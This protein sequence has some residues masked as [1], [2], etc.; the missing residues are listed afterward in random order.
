MELPNTTTHLDESTFLNQLLVSEQG[1]LKELAQIRESRESVIRAAIYLRVSTARQA[2]KDK[3]SLKEQQLQANEVI[4]NNGWI[5]S[6]VYK[7]AGK[8][9]KQV[10]GRDEYIRMIDD[11][12]NRKFEVIVFWDFD[13]F[14]RGGAGQVLSVRDELMGYGVQITSVTCPIEIDDPRYMTSETSFPKDVLIAM[15]AI[16]AKEENRK[17]A[18]R[19]S[20]AKNDKAKRGYIPCKVPYGYRKIVKHNDDGTKTEK[21]VIHKKEALVVQE[22]FNLYDQSSVGILRVAEHLNLKGIPASR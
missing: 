10:V 16:V 15:Q 5:L 7:D 12:K 17:R 11:A 21:V 3:A 14:G 2:T 13:R 1:K 4:K 8:S 19:M 22:I 18:L 6:D 20:L 9:G